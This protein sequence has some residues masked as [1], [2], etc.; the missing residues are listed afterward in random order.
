MLS[1]QSVFQPQCP[2]ILFQKHLGSSSFGVAQEGERDGSPQQLQHFRRALAY[3]K[4]T[5]RIHPESG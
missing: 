4:T 3:R 5:F 1:K 2:S